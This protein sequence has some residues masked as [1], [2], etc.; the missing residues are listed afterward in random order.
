MKTLMDLKK[1]KMLAYVVTMSFL[2]IHIMLFLLF[3]RYG[4]TPMMYFN[5]F[6][7]IFYVCMIP[8]V[9]KAYLR[10]FV[11]VVFVEV[12][13]HMA[14]ATYFTG[15]SSGF[16]TSM[17]GL[18]ILGFCSEYI[19]HHIKIPAVSSVKLGVFDMA[20]YLVICYIDHRRPA[21]YPLPEDVAF[22]LRV[23]W[24]VIT[25]GMVMMFLQL[26]IRTSTD[27]EDMLSKEVT[28]D[29]LT[30]LPN[31][32]FVS[33][34][35]GELVNDDGLVGYWAAMVDIDDFK[36]VNDTYGHNCG[37]YVLRE[38]AT[39][40]TGSGIEMKVTRW[41]GEEFL[42]IGKI[43]NNLEEELRKLD[44]L[45]KLVMKYRFVYEGQCLNLTVTMGVAE[46]APGSTIREWINQA[47]Q[48]LY[49][50]KTNGKNQVVA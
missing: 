13:A 48:R 4:V 28:H 42:L 36:V 23:I 16:Q 15:W 22:R 7:M 21:P 3:K 49:D 47:D 18:T 33:D 6:S 31:R 40:L 35:L 43:E 46:Y 30:G 37:D 26:Y 27:S 10:T 34:Y 25:F 24:G 19:A 32:Y 39:L 38:L 44:F 17:I 45:R 41:G 29:Q 2:V 50:G 8:V 5:I 14:L 9:E 20:V 11:V 1:T 12:V